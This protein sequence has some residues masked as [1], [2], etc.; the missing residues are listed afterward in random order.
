M[1]EGGSWSVNL[2]VV[3]LAH[4]FAGD[5]EFVGVVDQT[6]EDGVGHGRVTEVAVPILHRKL[7]GD[8]RGAFVVAVLQDFEQG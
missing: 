7:A 8:E 6:V 3:P 2:V 5:L 4:G 1:I